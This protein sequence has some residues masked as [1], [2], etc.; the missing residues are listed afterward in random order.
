[1]NWK[2]TK[3]LINADCARLP[4][5]SFGKFRYLLSN[6]SFKITFWFRIGSYLKNKKGFWKILYALVVLIHKHNAYKTGIQMPFG[7]TVGGGYFLHTL[8]R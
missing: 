3:D 5:K 8:A 2:E 1:M 6:H 7:T 4:Q